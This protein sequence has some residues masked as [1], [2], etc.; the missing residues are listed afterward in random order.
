VD[1]P[2]AAPLDRSEE[3]L[4]MAGQPENGANALAFD[5][6]RHKIGS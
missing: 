1:E 2:H 5:G 6:C 3:R 4:E